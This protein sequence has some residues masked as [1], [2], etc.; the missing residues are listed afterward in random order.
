MLAREIDQYIEQT[1]IKRKKIAEDAGLTQQQLSDICHG[2]R[3]IEAV[4]YFN[5]C[6]ALNVSLDFFPERLSNQ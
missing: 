1:G 5:I 6:K 2:K 3:K 4:E